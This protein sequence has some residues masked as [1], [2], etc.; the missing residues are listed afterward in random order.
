MV[1]NMCRVVAN[2]VQTM[3]RRDFFTQTMI[4]R[5]F[6]FPAK[7]DER[8]RDNVVIKNGKCS[9]LKWERKCCVTT[10]DIIGT[11]IVLRW[12]NEGTQ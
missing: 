12:Y 10:V 4:R 2:D 9:E 3:I 5:D 8:E 7:D 1:M 11:I 6:F